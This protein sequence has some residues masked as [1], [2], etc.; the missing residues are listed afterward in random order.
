MAGPVPPA[1]GC[2]PGSPGEGPHLRGVV[3]KGKKRNVTLGGL[4]EQPQ[5]QDSPPAEQAAP[6]AGHRGGRGAGW[7]PGA[8]V[9]PAQGTY[10]CPHAWNAGC[11]VRPYPAHS[12]GAQAHPPQ[13]QGT[14]ARPPPAAWRRRGKHP[15]GWPRAPPTAARIAPAPQALCPEMTLCAPTLP[16]PRGGPTLLEGAQIQTLG[17]RRRAV[18]GK[19]LLALRPREAMP[20]PHPVPGSSRP[21]PAE[22]Q[23]PSREGV[24]RPSPLSASLS[25]GLTPPPRPH[26]QTPHRERS[27]PGPLTLRGLP[28]A[29]LEA[30]SPRG[31]PALSSRH[32]HHPVRSC[33]HLLPPG[34]QAELLGRN[35]QPLSTEG[36][37]LRPQEGG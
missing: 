1:H 37:G 4:R 3:F 35:R 21:H 17:Q 27:L 30:R 16:A 25:C 33:G 36:K 22:P 18:S 28:R 5:K 6:G 34:V 19:V 7:A 32:P 13:L 24:P 9:P 10:Q 31:R 15:L 14:W 23:R 8:R 12:L 2:S 26:K 11:G 29:P 20:G